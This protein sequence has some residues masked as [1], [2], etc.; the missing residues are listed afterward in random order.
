MMF[1]FTPVGVTIYCKSVSAKMSLYRIS[2]VSFVSCSGSS[3]ST[4]LDA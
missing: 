1:S 2:E 3:D 4:G